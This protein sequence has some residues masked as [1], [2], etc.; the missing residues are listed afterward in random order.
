MAGQQGESAFGSVVY[1]NE[2][3]GAQCGTPFHQP[4]SNQAIRRENLDILTE[5]RPTLDRI[6]LETELTWMHLPD[7]CAADLSVFSACQ[8]SGLTFHTIRMPQPQSNVAGIS[9]SNI[10]TL[11]DT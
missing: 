10:I 1:I 11:I 7:V 6:P 9:W 2:P 3:R 8:P 5:G 4:A